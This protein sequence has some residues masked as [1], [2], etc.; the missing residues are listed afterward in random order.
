ME[1]N[2]NYKIETMQL[3][4]LSYTDENIYHFSEGL[5]G[6]EDLKN[7]ILVS[8]GEDS[9][10]FYLQSIE[11]VNITFIIANPFV[12][13]KSYELNIASVD[14][15]SIDLKNREAAETWAIVTMSKNIEDITANFL[16]PLVINSNNRKGKQVISLNSNYSTK[17][18]ILV[19]KILN[20]VG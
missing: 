7:F 1:N 9:L 5:Y 13:D 6:F 11:D 15:E 17:H 20:K 8:S 12:L 14:Y 16:G 19:E 10:F 4:E 2:K 18:K 3:G